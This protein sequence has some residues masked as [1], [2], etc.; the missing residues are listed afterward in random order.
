MN[1]YFV[2]FKESFEAVIL[3]ADEAEIE[4]ESE[5]RMLIFSDK[6]GKI[7]ASFRDWIYFRELAS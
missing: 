3:H 7:L 5:F 4:Y 1:R 2:L 6:D